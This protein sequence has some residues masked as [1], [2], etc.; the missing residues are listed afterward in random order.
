MLHLENNRRTSLQ[1]FPES[2]VREIESIEAE[3]IY[4]VDDIFLINKDRL[5]KIA[6]LLLAKNIRKKYLVYARA[7]FIAQN[8]EVIKEWSALGLRAVFI[9]LE[10]TTDEELKGMNKECDAVYNRKAIEVL[11]KYKV[12]TYG[13]LIPG[14]EY[15]KEDWEKLWQFIED[16]GLYYINISPHTPLPGADI[17]PL[18]KN[19]ITV[20][21]DAHGLFDLSHMILP[22][23]MSL[24]QFY[25]ELLKLYSRTILNPKRANQN[26]YRTLPSIWSLKYLRMILGTLKIRRQ[27][28]RAHKHHSPQEIALARYKGKEVKDLTFEYKFTKAS[29]PS[30]MT[31]RPVKVL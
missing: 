10:A 21:E 13:S 12:D 14:A 28:L 26:T 23:K 17:W 11:K 30:S 25:R 24:K 1:P 4:I 22:T 8:E 6:D 7:D 27:F 20:P 16:S 5:R 29:F 18:F 15:E 19:Q 3:D 9:G 2:I 31:T